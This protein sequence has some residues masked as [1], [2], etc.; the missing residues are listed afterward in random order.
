VPY[1]KDVG[2]HGVQGQR[3][4]GEALALAHGRRRGWKFET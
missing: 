2:A 1:H 4:I 3:R